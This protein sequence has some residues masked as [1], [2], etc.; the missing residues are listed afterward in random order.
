MLK[1]RSGQQYTTVAPDGAAGYVSPHDPACPAARRYLP[2]HRVDGGGWGIVD[3][4]TARLLAE[5]SPHQHRYASWHDVQVAV[6]ALN[7]NAPAAP[8][9]GQ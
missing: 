8:G 5:A 6:D 1:G 4:R 2:V 9:E 7:S 3:R